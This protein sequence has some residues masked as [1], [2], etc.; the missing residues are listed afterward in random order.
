MS[1]D[2]LFEDLFI[3]SSSP[4][5]S[6]TSAN[7]SN[8]PLNVLEILG[9]IEEDLGEDVEYEDEEEC[10]AG[11]EER[12]ADIVDAA[13]QDKPQ[14]PS[15]ADQHVP[16]STTINLD[17]FTMLCVVGKGGFGKVHQVMKKD[18][19]Q[20][21]AMKI[22]KKRHL[23]N[24]K[25]VENTMAEKDIL[26]KVQHPFIVRLVYAFQT[27][28]KLHLV[29]DFVNGGHLLFHLH[30]EAM[31]SEVQARF[32]IAEVILAI[33]HLHKQNIIHRD[34]KPEN[35]LLDS[36]GH[37][38]L[39]DFGFAKENVADL[40]SCN[41]FCGTLEYMAPEVVKRNRY[42]KPADWW[43]VGILLYDMLAGQ[44]PFRHQ[45][46][47]ALY[48]K[49]LS[50]KLSMPKYLTGECQSLI[51]GLLQRDIKKRLKVAAI[52]NH[53]FFKPINWRK[54]EKMEIRPPFLP[55]TP[56]GTLDISNFDADL[57]KLKITTDSPSSPPLSNSQQRQFLGFSYVSNGECFPRDY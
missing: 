13:S 28:N 6:R 52:K 16:L 36:E 49:I 56:K 37:V 30:R 18:T 12:A 17:T 55:I 41:S 38:R 43:S 29:M 25:S 47:N 32:Y 27:A 33:E 9:T 2:F 42:G 7:S 54:L 21:Y 26:R 57:T 53:S 14:P 4:Q 23:I 19:Y 15:E 22:L 31:F 8:Q 50:D 39:T 44:P 3:T 24:T 1:E 48:K 35:V 45:N 20:V 46:D 11:N 5:L 34:L 10:E 40:D 51:R